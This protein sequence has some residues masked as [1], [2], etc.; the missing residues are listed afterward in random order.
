[1]SICTEIFFKTNKK[2]EKKWH[3]NN[4]M[5]TFDAI[6]MGLFYVLKRLMTQ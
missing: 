1:V 2:I 4:I 3:K 5:Y 6:L